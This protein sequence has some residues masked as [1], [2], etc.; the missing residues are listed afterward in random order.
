MKKRKSLA[1]LVVFIFL[2]LPTYIFGQ[3]DSTRYPIFDLNFEAGV[4]FPQSEDFQE[5]YNTKSSFNWSIGSKFGTSEWKFLPWMK[6]SQYESRVDS[7]IVNDEENDSLL[8]A[9][10]KQISLGFVHPIDLRND[11]YFQIKCGITYNFISE[12]L[13][14]LNS[15]P[16]GLIMSVGYMKRLSKYMTYYLDLNY[17]YAK[18]TSGYRFKDWSGFLVNSGI[19]INLG[20]DE[21]MR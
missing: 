3:A 6:Y 2:L 13:T 19:S 10:R 11:N 5:V 12:E 7:V 16:F 15:E 18:A 20:A 1:S 17:D 8:I 4:F 9:G 14:D 21:P